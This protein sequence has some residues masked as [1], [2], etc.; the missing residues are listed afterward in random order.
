MDCYFSE[1]KKD[2]WKRG[3]LLFEATAREANAFTWFI[4]FMRVE[5][6]GTLLPSELLIHRLRPREIA[7]RDFTG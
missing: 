3:R 6:W 5:E 4:G 1:G 2:Q 7:L